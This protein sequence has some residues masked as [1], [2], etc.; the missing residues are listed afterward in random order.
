MRSL[1]TFC[2]SLFLVSASAQITYETVYVDYDSAWQFKNLK[3][4]P[5]RRKP[6]GGMP[7]ATGT[8][9]VPLAEA[10]SK[11]LVTVTERGTTS[12][13]NVH[14][15]RFNTK[16]NKSVYIG[17]GEIVMGGRQDRMIVRDT[18]LNPSDKD[19]YVPVMCVEEGRWS[20]KEKKFG[21]G[22][23]AN[24][25]LRKV[26]D[27]G[28]NQVLIW[29]EVDRQLQAGQ[30][31]NKS[32][33]YESRFLD[34]KHVLAGNE[35]VKYFMDKFRNSDSTIVGFIA[36]SGDKVIGSDVFDGTYLFYHQL[37]PLL[38]GYVDEAVTSGSPVTLNNDAVR[39][40]ADKLLKDEKTQEKFVNENGKIFRVAAHVVHINTFFKET[41]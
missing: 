6:G 8:N 3:I 4:Y 20:E 31:K 38:R 5:I 12:F 22:N 25:D 7:A 1:F 11:G 33:A 30:F 9:V 21:Y 35:Y 27:S 15:L 36:V 17:G 26:M 39:R 40:Y 29:R 24:N 34:K 32:L 14:W 2:L 28:R 19:Q 10:L 41:P 18:I 13:E 37:E 16:S 23:Y